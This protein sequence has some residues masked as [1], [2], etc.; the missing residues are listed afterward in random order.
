MLD[1][2]VAKMPKQGKERSFQGGDDPHAF[3]AT[4]RAEQHGAL[5]FDDAGED[6][7][8]PGANVF[9]AELAPVAV[10]LKELL[11][12]RWPRFPKDGSHP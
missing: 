2:C 7:S 1:P 11:E 3:D 8:H 10:R 12:S 5:S 6:R 9:L 4:T